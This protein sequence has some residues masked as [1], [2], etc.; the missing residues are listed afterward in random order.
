MKNKNKIETWLPVFSGFYSNPY[1]EEDL[2]YEAQHFLETYGYKGENGYE[3]E[4]WRF[5]DYD[6]WHRDICKRICEV[7]E[8]KLSDFV[9]SIEY[10]KIVSPREYNFTNDGV[11]C[12]IVPKIQAI[13]NFVYD[14]KEAYEK[15]LKDHYTSYDGFISS[16]HNYFEAW[17]GYTNGFTDYSGKGHYLGSVLQFICKQLEITEEN[18]YEEVRVDGEIHESEYF[19]D[20]LYEKCEKIETFVR[21]NYSNP[22]RLNLMHEKFDPKEFDFERIID[23]VDTE[24]EKQTLSIKFPKK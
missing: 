8:E 17:E 9:E 2:E 10:E 3:G 16:Y 14:N 18:I 19:I 6:K 23:K 1:W 15:Y 20:E 24:I 4:L 11:D 22:D 7:L 13:K 5:F 12:A 21:E